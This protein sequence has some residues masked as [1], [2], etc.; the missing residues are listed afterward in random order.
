MIVGTI[1]LVIII[2]VGFALN[3]DILNSKVRVLEDKNKEL[4]LRVIYLNNK[5]EDFERGRLD[6]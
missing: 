3:F 1:I 6:K 2:V 5:M 4:E